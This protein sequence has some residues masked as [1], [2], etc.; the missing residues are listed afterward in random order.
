MARSIDGMV[1]RKSVAPRP[2]AF[3]NEKPSAVRSAMGALGRY[4]V[5]TLAAVMRNKLPSAGLSKMR[6][7]SFRIEPR[8]TKY[9]QCVECEP[10]SKARGAVV[11]LEL[12]A[13]FIGKGIGFVTAPVE[14]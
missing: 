2:T 13:R 14:G 3:Y 11:F 4:R 5:P 7:Q 9:I 6:F 12:N 10:L 1:S 8:P